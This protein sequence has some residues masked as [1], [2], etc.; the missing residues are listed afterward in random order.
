LLE[1][2]KTYFGDCLEVM[3]LIDDASVDMILCDL[4]YAVTQNAWD[5]IIPFDLLWEQY[6]RIIADNGAI[7]LTSM[8]PFSSSL[9]S[10]NAKMFRYEW[11]WE[12][13]QGTGFLNANRQPLR[14]HENILVFY[15]KQPLYNPQF[16]QGKPYQSKAGAGKTSSNYGKQR[17]VIVVNEG[18]RHPLTVLRFKRDNPKVHPTQKPVALFE[19]LI[20][21]YTN[22]GMVV[23]DN[24]AGSGTTGLACRNTGRNYILIEK[25]ETYYDLIKQRL[26]E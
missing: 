3:K 19:Y 10:S 23:L 6:S 13:P 14:N 22:E 25:D 21:T 16:S 1:L 4:P 11:I 12:K 20:R 17:E 8:Q 2:N 7:V 15:K 26:N 18:K 9:I 24:C 5:S